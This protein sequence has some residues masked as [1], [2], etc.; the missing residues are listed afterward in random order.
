MAHYKFIGQAGVYVERN[1]GTLEKCGRHWSY[2][3]PLYLSL[4]DMP[5]TI[6]MPI[7]KKQ[8]I[9]MDEQKTGLTEEKR[10]NGE[11]VILHLG[12]KWVTYC[13]STKIK[14]YEEV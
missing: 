11:L 10:I 3:K 6:T 2:V 5:N 9:N 7:D 12:N 14:V 8:L 4:V 1:D 13:N